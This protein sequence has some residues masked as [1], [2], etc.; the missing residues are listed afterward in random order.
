M[1][2]G[3]E[4]V[5]VGEAARILGISVAAVRKR[6][7]RGS[8]RAWKVDGV[9]RV[10]LPAGPEPGRTES[11]DAGQDVSTT[12]LIAQL[13]GE[14]EF[15]RGLVAELVGRVPAQPAELPAGTVEGAPPVA[16]IAAPVPVAQQA[17]ERPTRRSRASWW[18]FWR[19]DGDKGRRR[20]VGPFLTLLRP[21]FR[22]QVFRAA[23]VQRP[24][25]ASSTCHR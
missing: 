21:S 11:V 6:I 13:R 4:P 5:D 3:P 1:T 16:E 2:T 12:A 22:C 23:R 8:L 14:N 18:A 9:W 25:T 24:I 15:L 10:V 19:R 7:R 17:A 20:A